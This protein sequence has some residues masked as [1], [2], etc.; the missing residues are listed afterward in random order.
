MYEEPRDVKLLSFPEIDNDGVLTP[1]ELL[2]SAA[3][4]AI[5]F[6]VKRI[7]FVSGATKEKPR[8]LHAHYV[9][10][11]VIF[12]AAGSIQCRCKDV[13]GHK[14]TFTLDSPGKGLYTPALVWDEQIYM[15]EETVLIALCSIPYDSK[16][17]IN[18]WTEFQNLKK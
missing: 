8:G 18:D 10:E 15:T 2:G 9:G 12:C 1:I 16:D 14:K 5:P 4:D 11:Q 7:F 6:D 13:F 17:Y 3:Q